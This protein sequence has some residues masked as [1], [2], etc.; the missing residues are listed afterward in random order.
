M[1]QDVVFHEDAFFLFILPSE[2]LVV[3]RP[4]CDDNDEL[5]VYQYGLNILPRAHYTQEVADMADGVGEI[6]RYLVEFQ[7][8]LL[9]VVR[10]VYGNDLGTTNFRVFMLQLQGVAGR[11]QMAWMEQFQLD[12]SMLFLAPGSSRSFD[13][14]EYD[15]MRDFGFEIAFLDESYVPEPAV[16]EQVN[17]EDGPASNDE[18]SV[19]ET[20]DKQ[21]PDTGCFSMVEQQ[22]LVEAEEKVIWPPGRPM[23]D[24]PPIWWFH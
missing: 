10:Y 17:C 15:G 5:R 18:G 13:I 8:R 9:M 2:D 12:G 16:I 6:K 3:L 21:C 24:T 23:S 11:P 4:V 14:S 19:H 22:Q 20:D 7:G 1:P